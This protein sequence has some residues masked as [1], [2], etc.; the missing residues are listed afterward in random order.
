MMKNKTL[1]AAAALCISA[2]A[3][4]GGGN[5]GP[6][7]IV[8]DLNGMN[9]YGLVGGIRAYSIG[10][11]ACNIGTSRANWIDNSV[12][13]PVIAQNLYRI[14]DGRM[15][16]IGQG[17]LKHSFASLQGSVCASCQNDGDFQH[18]GTG[19]SD[20][21]DAGLNGS[22][23]GM[24]PRFQVNASTGSFPW[25]YANPQGSSGNAIFKRI[26]VPVDL[27]TSGNGEVY[28]AEGQYVTLDDA[29]AGNN[30]NNC[31]YERA[32][33][34]TNGSFTLTGP[35][36]R[37]RPAIFAWMDHGNGANNPDPSVQI[38]TALI[39]DD[40]EFNVAGKATDNGDGTWRYD[41]A[42]HNENSHRSANSISIPKAAGVS[43]SDFFFHAP[44]SHSG[45]TYNNDPWTVSDGASEVSWSTDDWSLANDN[46]T[47]A[48]R[49]GEM[50]TY[51]FVANT[52]PVDGSVTIGLFRPGAGV[53]DFSV[54]LPI[55]SAGMAG[56]NEAD[57]A[58]PFGSLDFSDVSAFLLAFS[59]SDP[60]ADIAV[61]FGAWDFSD[62][63]AFLGAFGAG[64]P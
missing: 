36:N 40:G 22:Q 8:G 41:Y 29:N 64:C 31:S 38:V 45:E 1:T 49:W 60:A 6:D 61:P 44:H 14:R 53:T 27:L 4:A 48:V 7:V 33:L 26:Q 18:L 47:N 10:T 16:H 35:T 46:V 25:P 15:L 34:N 63:A 19:C 12:N 13:H 56:C 23:T 24:G 2:T 52:P 9:H 11:T 17:W 37:E 3:F 32:N 57:I 54:T 58:E 5:P 28:I 62:V 21:Y 30:Y 55:P 42:I 50:H 43:V 51:S 39:P 20:P 59:T